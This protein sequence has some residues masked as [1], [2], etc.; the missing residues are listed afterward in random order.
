L[1]VISGHVFGF[2]NNYSV[3]IH[4][5]HVPLFFFISGYLFHNYEM[6]NFI[7][8]KFKRLIFPYFGFGI[9]NYLLCI[10]LFEKF[11]YKGFI[12][13]FFLYN[14][15]P[16]IPVAGALWFLTGL[17]FANILFILLTKF[18]QNMH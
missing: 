16:S 8:K 2:E 7:L 9:L 1:F 17:F 10:I 12:N 11:D 4:S 5:F 6:K 18:F 3:Y 14:N 15:E 13:S